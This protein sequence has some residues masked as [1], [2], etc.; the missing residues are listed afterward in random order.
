MTAEI[1]QFRSRAQIEDDRLNNEMWDIMAPLLH[2]QNE[3]Y[4]RHLATL[5]EI[6]DGC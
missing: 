5:K 6:E 4:L 1:I 3:D 2:E